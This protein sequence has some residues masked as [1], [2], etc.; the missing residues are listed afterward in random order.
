L[1]A[2]MLESASGAGPT[3]EFDSLPLFDDAHPCNLFDS[4]AGVFDNTITGGSAVNAALFDSIHN[5]FALVNGPNGRPMGRQFTTVLAPASM[6]RTFRNFLESDLMY[7]ATLAGGS[8]T[9]LTANNIHKG[10]VDLVICNELTTS[11]VF[12]AIDSNGPKPWIVQDGGTPEEIRYDKDSELYKSQGKVGVKYVLT[13]G[14]KAALP[15][16][17]IR[18]AL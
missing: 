6:A 11:G 1:I 8:G 13:Q 18:V 17:I 14:V 4:A 3:L 12:Y 10:T 16:S 9:A 7:N 5:R 15:H 2:A